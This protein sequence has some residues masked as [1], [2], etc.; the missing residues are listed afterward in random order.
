MLQLFA[1]LCKGR[2][3]LAVGC[4]Q[5]WVTCPALLQLLRHTQWP[6]HMRCAAGELLLQAYVDVHP[7]VFVSLPRMSRT[8]DDA[9]M[10]APTSPATAA[11]SSVPGASTSPPASVASPSPSMALSR[12]V[13]M[14]VAKSPSAVAS[15]RALSD[16]ADFVVE[17][18]RTIQL[19]QHPDAVTVRV[20]EIAHALLRICA[21][22]R[23]QTLNIVRALT[24]VLQSRTVCVPSAGTTHRATGHT[25]PHESGWQR[26]TRRVCVSS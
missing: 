23:G 11:P 3:V 4:V 9:A 1:G 17:F 14:M 7:H 13:P 24:D 6:Q 19:R 22:S 8:L 5:R 12:S 10:L 16:V 2:H 15:T 25:T 26:A 21:W 20:I 18:L